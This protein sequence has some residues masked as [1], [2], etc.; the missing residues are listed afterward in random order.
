MMTK[1]ENGGE[2]DRWTNDI[3]T[4]YMDAF[5]FFLFLFSFSLFSFF[6]HQWL[7]YSKFSSSF[8]FFFLSPKAKGREEKKEERKGERERLS[9]S[10]S[11][12]FSWFLVRW[13]FAFQSMTFFW[14]YWAQKWWFFHSLLRFCEGEMKCGGRK[15]E[16]GRENKRKKFEW[17]KNEGKKETVFHHHH[18]HHHLS[19]PQKGKSSYNS[20]HSL[21]SSL[22][23]SV[24]HS[25]L[26]FVLPSFNHH[27]IHYFSHLSRTIFF[28]VLNASTLFLLSFPSLSLSSLFLPLLFLSFSLSL[29]FSD[30]LPPQS[31]I[32]RKL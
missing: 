21:S 11:K 31:S 8:P 28:L 13:T 25:S 22:S 6:F 18:H 1:E 5:F 24:I 2:N 4:I 9:S 7:S 10:P 12:L 14:T 27:I 16:R 17:Q 23:L 32:I 30:S 20:I 15:R 3:F 19:L 26:T 29:S